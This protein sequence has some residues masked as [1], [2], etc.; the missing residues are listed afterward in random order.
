[1]A[2]LSSYFGWQEHIARVQGHQHACMHNSCLHTSARAGSAPLVYSMYSPAWTCV[3][4]YATSTVQTDMQ[5]LAVAHI[6]M[7]FL[8]CAMGVSA[9][10]CNEGALMV[11]SYP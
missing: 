10:I 9:M 8:A 6:R 3:T 2:M 5:L 1:M 11:S 7:C 4:L